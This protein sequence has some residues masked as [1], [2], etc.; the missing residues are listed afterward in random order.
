MDALIELRGWCKR[1]LRFVWI[2]QYL[3]SCTHIYKKK[4]NKYCQKSETT[5][6]NNYIFWN[7]HQIN[8]GSM[9][10]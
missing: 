4:K 9:A 10:L 1:K 5:S 3:E 2:I 7:W 8:V 6:I